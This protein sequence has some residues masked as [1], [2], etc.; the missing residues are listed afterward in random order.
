MAWRTPTD[1]EIAALIATRIERGV[2]AAL[3][4]ALDCAWWLVRAHVADVHLLPRGEALEPPPA[5][6]L[7]RRPSEP[8]PMSPQGSE[9]LSEPAWPG[10]LARTHHAA[11]EAT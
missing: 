1:A 11:G 10:R 2:A 7:E 9:A 4:Q 3:R 8:D 5:M 6:W